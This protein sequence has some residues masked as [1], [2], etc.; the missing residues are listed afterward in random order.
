MYRCACSMVCVLVSTI[1]TAAQP[2]NLTE[3]SPLGEQAQFVVELELKGN[4]I[5][6]LENGKQPIPIAAKA[7]HRFAERCQ[8]VIDGLPSTTIRLYSEAKASATIAAEKSERSLSS[9]RKLI[10]ARR[11]AD[12]LFCFAPNGPLTRDELDLVTDHFNPQCLPGLLPGKVVNIGDTWTLTDATV[13]TACHFDATIKASI[14]G[15]LASVKDGLAT[16][17]IDG[18]AEGLENGAKL[19]LEITAHGSFDIATGH[20]VALTWKQKDEREQGAVNPASQVEASVTLKREKSNVEPKELSDNSLAGIPEGDLPAR[21]TDLRLTDAK[22]RYQL[23]HSRD[24]HVTGQTDTHLIMRLLDRGELVAQATVTVW[25][26]MEPGKHLA[27]EDFKKAVSAAPGWTLGKV[28]FDREMPATAGRWLY[29][30][31][32]EGK[33]EDVP[34]VQTFYLLAGPQGD[35]LAVTVATKPDKLKAIGNRDM[36]LVN[37]IEFSK[38]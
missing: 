14:V 32:I 15:K 5:V 18:T 36:N 6:A 10:A 25:N 13:Q 4:L 3:K 30:L 22:G 26:K 12:G 11:N 33:M 17:N 38:K 19:A 20:I 16:F 37:S 28:L 21:L 29:R 34:V 31:S 9:D 8:A 1:S 24:W 2:I 23:M 7:S 35:Q 27:I